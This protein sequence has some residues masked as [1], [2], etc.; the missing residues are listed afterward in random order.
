[1]INT[2]TKVSKHVKFLVGNQ[3]TTPTLNKTN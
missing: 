1:M 3:I 2:S